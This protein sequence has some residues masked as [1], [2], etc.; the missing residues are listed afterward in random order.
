[1]SAPQPLSPATATA[2]RAR[3]AASGGSY[4]WFEPAKEPPAA[5]WPLL[6]FLHG[7]GERGRNLNDLTRYGPTKLLSGTALLTSAEAEIARELAETFAVLA[8]QCTRDEVWE[9]ER[10]LA[11][12]D[13][14][15]ARERVDRGRV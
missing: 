15:V 11:L 8:P 1:M 14:V 6:V 5:G 2:L 3:T 10:L 13:A 4:L 12:V 7:A 9:E